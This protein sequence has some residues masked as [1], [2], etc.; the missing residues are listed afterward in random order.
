MAPEIFLAADHKVPY[1]GQDADLFALGV[2]LFATHFGILP[3]EQAKLNDE[4][5]LSIIGK[6][7][8]ANWNWGHFINQCS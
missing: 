5:Y 4:K 2:T 1:Q 8:S 6:V 7:Q 3:F